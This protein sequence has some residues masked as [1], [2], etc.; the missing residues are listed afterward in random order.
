MRS[1]GCVKIKLPITHYQG[2]FDC[3][4]NRDLPML[5]VIGPMLKL[6]EV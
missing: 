4:F 5:E 3:G 6:C 1:R 2:L